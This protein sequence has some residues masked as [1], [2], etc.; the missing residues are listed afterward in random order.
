M[1]T[2]EFHWLLRLGQQKHRTQDAQ[3]GRSA[4]PQRVKACGVPLWYV[5]G[6]NDARTPLAE[7]FSILL[8]DD[9][10]HKIIQGRIGYLDLDEF[11]CCG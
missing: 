1:G 5:E 10:A 2:L 7:F 11:P 4:R 9:V 8:L 3:I 6:L